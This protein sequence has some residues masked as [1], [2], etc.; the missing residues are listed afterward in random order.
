MALASH[1]FSIVLDRDEVTSRM[2]RLETQLDEIQRI[3]RSHHDH[4]RREM[5]GAVHQMRHEIKELHQLLDNA[6]AP[7]SF[8]RSLRREDDLDAMTDP[9]FSRFYSQLQRTTFA[10]SKKDLVTDVMAGASV[11][12]DQVARVMGLFTFSS[13]KI[14]V[15][16]IMYPSVVDPHN[17]YAVYSE[18]T[19]E[20]DRKKLRR[21]IATQ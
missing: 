2:H 6:K 4:H 7:R 18:L 11:T 20:S 3:A 21:K 19:F 8:E 12:S 16:A 10:S 13:D 9:E 17:F 1:G 15:A 5:M 14:A